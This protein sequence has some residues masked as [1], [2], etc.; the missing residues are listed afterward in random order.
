MTRQSEVGRA[1]SEGGYVARRLEDWLALGPEWREG[2]TAEQATPFQNPVFLETWYR[3]FAKEEGCAPL[4]IDIRDA[5][6]RPALLFPLVVKREGRLSIISFAD[7]EISDNNAPLLGKA[8]PKTPAQMRRAW[9]ALRAVLPAHDVLR[10]PKIPRFIG[11]T[12][13]PLMWLAGMEASPLNAHPLDLGEDWAVYV[14]N[15]TKKFRKEQARV[16]RVFQRHDAARFDIITDPAEAVGLFDEFERHQS[17]RIRSLGETYHLDGADYR[18]FYRDFLAQ[19]LPSG[20]AVLGVLRAGDEFV[21][22]LMGICNERSIVFVRLSHAGGAWSTCSPGRLVI[23]RVL[24][25]AHGAGYRRIDFSIGDYGYKSDFGISTE[26]LF[27][28]IAAGSLKGAIAT[29]L[30]KLKALARRSAVLRSLKARLRGRRIPALPGKVAV[31]P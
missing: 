4:V 26:G 29:A 13:N 16:W 8:A 14:R 17:Q 5:A 7:A 20:K 2:I 18:A 30:P 9:E 31:A 6:G 3:H 27:E 15:R 21:S 19:G 10:L 22:G 11:G 12:I 28:F 23:E 1:S 24:E 25:W